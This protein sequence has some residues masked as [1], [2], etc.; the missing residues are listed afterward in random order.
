TPYAL[1]NFALCSFAG[2]FSY[3]AETV[4]KVNNLDGLLLK[5]REQC[6][7][8]GYTEAVRF[9]FGA[10]N[11]DFSITFNNKVG[12]FL[13]GFNPRKSQQFSFGTV[14]G[15]GEKAMLEDFDRLGA[16]LQRHFLS[17]CRVCNG[18]RACEKGGRNKRFAVKITYDGEERTLC[19]S[20]PRHSWETLS[21]ELI[22]TLFAYHDAQEV[23]GR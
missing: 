16:D 17:I 21:Q 23:Y 1:A 6:L 20:F 3:L 19:P 15:I 18:C 14:N 2:D 11:F 5:L 7:K 4:D 8:K 9:N 10:T 13:I 22:D 12:G